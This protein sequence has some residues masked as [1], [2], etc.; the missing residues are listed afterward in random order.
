MR[1]TFGVL[2][3]EYL[4]QVRRLRLDDLFRTVLPS[5]LFVVAWSLVFPLVMPLRLY[6]VLFP[7]TPGWA[8]FNISLVVCLAIVGVAAAGLALRW[9]EQRS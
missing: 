1:A 8:I 2:R 9:L 3:Y 4:M 7:A 5:W 6:Q